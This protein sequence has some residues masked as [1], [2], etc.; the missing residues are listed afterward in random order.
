[1][2]KPIAYVAIPLNL[3]AVRDQPSFSPAIRPISVK[4]EVI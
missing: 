1:M 4:T 2:R 3:A